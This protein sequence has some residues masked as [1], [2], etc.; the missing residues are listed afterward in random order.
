MKRFFALAVLTVLAGCEAPA[1]WT[2]PGATER[3]FQ[4]SLARCRMQAAG[5]PSDPDLGRGNQRQQMGAAMQSAG[6]SISY[7]NNCLMADGWFRE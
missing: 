6:A 5:R 1:P 7:I 3:D 4:M 2:K